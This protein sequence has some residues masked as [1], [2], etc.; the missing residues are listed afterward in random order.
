MANEI[1]IHKEEI[2]RVNRERKMAV[3]QK[4]GFD[5]VTA[6]SVTDAFTVLDSQQYPLLWTEYLKA[7][8]IVPTTVSCE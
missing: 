6:I 3:S 7:N 4:V 1:N 8:T 2:I 5:V